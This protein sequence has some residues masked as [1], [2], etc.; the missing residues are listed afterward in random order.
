MK[1]FKKGFSKV[2]K[3]VGTAV[4]IGLV[5]AGIGF[6]VYTQFIKKDEDVKV[7]ADG[8]TKKVD[9]NTDSTEVT[10]CN[11]KREL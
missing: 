7:T 1:N 5:S 11:I 9:T 2:A 10:F 6:L 4:I 8:W 3:A